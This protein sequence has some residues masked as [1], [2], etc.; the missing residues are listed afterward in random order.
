M[1]T[2]QFESTGEG[3]L[4]CL[5][6]VLTQIILG[7]KSNRCLQPYPEP[8]SDLSFDICAQIDKDSAHAGKVT[9]LANYGF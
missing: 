2:L 9:L 1:L 5:L 3:W 7:S 8:S 6:I 4:E